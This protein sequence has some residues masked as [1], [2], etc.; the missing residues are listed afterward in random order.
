MTVLIDRSLRL[1]ASEYFPQVQRKSGIARHYTVG[2][3]AIP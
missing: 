1:H 2:G 3:S